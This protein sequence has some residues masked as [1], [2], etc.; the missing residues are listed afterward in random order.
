MADTAELALDM[1]ASAGAPRA[2]ARSIQASPEI[3]AYVREQVRTVPDWPVAGV[4]FRDITPLFSSP[5]VLHRIVETFV[6]RYRGMRID[7]FA[8]LEAR[9]FILAPLLAYE[10]KAAFVPIRKKGKL[11][12]DTISESYKLEY[13]EATVEVHTDACKPG[14]RV[15]L[16]D[17]LI[18]TGGTLMAGWRLMERLGANV[19]EAAALIDLP[20]LG[21]SARLTQAGLPLFTLCPFAGH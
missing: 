14:A 4:Q 3:G 7:A 20:E 13:G 6:D 16:V 9:G 15:V 12:F 18:A 1:T 10:L 19:V 2:A 21:G 11:P 5:D 17:D 8:G